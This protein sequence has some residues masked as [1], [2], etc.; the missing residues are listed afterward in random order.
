MR[1]ERQEIDIPVDILGPLERL[2]VLHSFRF[3]AYAVVRSCRSGHVSIS[4]FQRDSAESAI[5]N[6]K[7]LRA[8]DGEG[9]VGAEAGERDRLA[10]R[11]W[12]HQPAW[13]WLLHRERIEV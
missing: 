13:M 5:D 2:G 6:L 4:S 10:D 8:I 9:S 3:Q 1:G 12:L 7:C 11:D